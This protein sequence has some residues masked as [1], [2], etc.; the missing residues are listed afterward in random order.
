MKKLSLYIFFLL[1]WCNVGFAIDNW[2]IEQVLNNEFTEV[3]TNGMVTDGD[4]YR[5]HISNNGK[6]NTVEDGFTFFTKANHPN[7]LNII[8]KK[9]L[10]E[11][12]GVKIFSEVKTV[13]P[14]M[15]GHLVWLTNGLYNIEE[16]GKFLEN[17]EK[18]EVNLIAVYYDEKTSWDAEDFFDILFNS[19]DLTNV[20]S[21]L[22][23]GKENCLNNKLN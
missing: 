10:L 22:M 14:A 18:L 16:H 15:G 9:V 4:R 19:W 8:G 2:R 20:Y 6:C 11:A 5:L 17:S 1:M 21:A 12:M 13:L 23:E 3:S 7:I